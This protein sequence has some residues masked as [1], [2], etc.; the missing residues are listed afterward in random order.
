MPLRSYFTY[1]CFMVESSS[2]VEKTRIRKK[3]LT[4]EKVMI[5]AYI[6]LSLYNEMCEAKSDESISRFVREAVKVRIHAIRIAKERGLWPN[7][8]EKTMGEIAS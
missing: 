7:D 6:P 5:K 4:L 2:V 8:T 1:F 3:L